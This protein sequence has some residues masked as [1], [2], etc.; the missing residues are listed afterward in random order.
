MAESR[1]EG[2]GGDLARR[3]AAEFVGTFFLV[4]VGVGAVATD[5][6][7]GGLGPVGVA[8]A[9]GAVVAAMV[10]ATGHISGAHLNPAVTL[11]FLSTGHVTRT[12]AAAYVGA[13]VLAAVV[14]AGALEVMLG[15]APAVGTTVPDVPLA[16]A[17]GVEVLITFALMFVIMAVATDPRATGSLAGVAIGLAVTMGA[18]MGGGPTGGSMNPA[19][20][21]GPALATG[22]WTAHWLYWV[23]PCVGAV[24][25]ARCYR[26]IQVVE[27]TPPTPGPS[28]E[29]V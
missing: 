2:A 27:V 9:F 1:R 29:R 18:L 24:A 4:F 15:L 5:A 17:F 28:K 13:Q 26:M 16:A 25:G 7:F 10:Y 8:L 3:G 21:F 12:D 22:E 20:S 6:A 23:A 19:R 11:G 14:A